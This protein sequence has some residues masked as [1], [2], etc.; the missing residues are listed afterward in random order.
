MEYAKLNYQ[1]EYQPPAGMLLLLA[2]SNLPGGS[3]LEND[4][5][6]TRKKAI[7]LCIELWTW[8]AETGKEKEGWP[9]WEKYGKIAAYCW[10]CE[11]NDNKISAKARHSASP[12]RSCKKCILPGNEDQRCHGLGFYKWVFA[13]TPDDH[14]KYAKLFLEQIKAL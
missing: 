13:N 5:R 8:L 2:Y 12:Y 4:M 7:E 14:K 10:F 11:Y 3:L 9:E 6:L 1:T